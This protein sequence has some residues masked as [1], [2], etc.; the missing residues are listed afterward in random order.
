M[1]SLLARHQT[2]WQK[3]EGCKIFVPSLTPINT[4]SPYMLPFTSNSDTHRHKGYPFWGATSRLAQT[5]QSSRT[6]NPR[7]S[8][9][10]ILLGHRENFTRVGSTPWMHQ[11]LSFTLSQSVGLYK[12]IYTVNQNRELKCFPPWAK[13]FGLYQV[14]LPWAKVLGSTKY[15]HLPFHWFFFFVFSE[16]VWHHCRVPA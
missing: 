10:Q 5:W 2:S 13:V 3:T 9:T 1:G 15:F 8:A 11:I 16:S 12:V 6:P 7:W 14:S 4:G